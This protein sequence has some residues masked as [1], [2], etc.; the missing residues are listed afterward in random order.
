MDVKDREDLL[1]SMSSKYLLKEIIK[2]VRGKCRQNIKQY[3]IIIL[4]N[5][6]GKDEPPFSQ[7]ISNRYFVH[8]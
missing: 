2:V 3:Q 6:A 5:F 4:S 8:K 7:Y 1:R